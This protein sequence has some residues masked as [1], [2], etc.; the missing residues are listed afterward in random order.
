MMKTSESAK[1]CSAGGPNKDRDVAPGGSQSRGE[2]SADSAGSDDEN[3]K[4]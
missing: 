4:G 3:A 2:V 1:L